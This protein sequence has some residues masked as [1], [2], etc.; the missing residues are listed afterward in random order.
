MPQ[1]FHFLGKELLR[2]AFAGLF[3]SGSL[4]RPK[5]GFVLLMASWISL[6]LQGFGDRAWSLVVL[7]ECAQREQMP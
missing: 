5:Q 3:S 1:R 6:Q 4:N 2:Q 7:G